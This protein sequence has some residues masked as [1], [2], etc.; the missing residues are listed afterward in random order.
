MQR[1]HRSLI[2]RVQRRVAVLGGQRPPRSRLMVRRVADRVEPLVTGGLEA[3][4]VKA[5]RAELVTS[6]DAWQIIA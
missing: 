4:T 5:S 1:P 3:A 2:N 6:F